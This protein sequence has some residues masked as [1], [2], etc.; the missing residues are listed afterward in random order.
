[1]SSATHYEVLGVARSAEADEIQ[2]AYR[3]LARTAHPDSGGSQG[4][5]LTIQSAYDTLRDPGR[6]AEYDR[7]LG[8]SPDTAPDQMPAGL[9]APAPS[10]QEAQFFPPLKRTLSASVSRWGIPGLV[11]AL[12][13]AGL[14]T[15]TWA[16]LDRRATR[17][18]LELSDYLEIGV[19]FTVA[20]VLAILAL[21]LGAGVIM[22]VTPE[23]IKRIFRSRVSHD[24]PRHDSAKRATDFLPA[25]LLPKRE[26]GTPGAGLSSARFGERAA[27]GRRGEE[28][29]ARII[30]ELIL[31]AV[32]GARVIHGASWPRSLHSDIDHIVVAGSSVLLVDSKLWSPGTYWSDGVTVYRSGEELPKLQLGS[33]VDPV[34]QL[35][36][37]LGCTVWACV[38]VHT[39]E[40]RADL[41]VIERARFAAPVT[42]SN[43]ST[44][45][46]LAMSALRPEGSSG[47]A[48]NV[49][50]LARLLTLLER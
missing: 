28:R 11:G 25:D 21:T 43:A 40:G 39:V 13:L 20:T 48:V 7:G 12:V 27:I 18:S 22:D 5:W 14:L 47:T 35:L 4:L 8:Q 45:V 37:G 46:H 26:F 33:A 17:G 34:A 24:R 1:M 44:F 3:R 31:P 38:V 2:R 42:V 50:A 9:V 32:P 23:W 49:A 41:P 30:R 29:T 19:F 15:M 10:N 16:L 6:R 36:S